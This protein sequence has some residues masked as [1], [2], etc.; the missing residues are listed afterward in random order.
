MFPCGVSNEGSNLVLLQDPLWENAQPKK[1]GRFSYK[2][3]GSQ[4][5]SQSNICSSKLKG[6]TTLEGLVTRTA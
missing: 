2:K 4:N 3:S 1:L 6:E 5:M